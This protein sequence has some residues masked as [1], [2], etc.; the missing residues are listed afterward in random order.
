MTFTGPGRTK[1]SFRDE[2]DIN[3]IMARFQKTGLIDFVEKNAPQYA[4]V[5]GL[6]FQACMDKI[7]SARE[8]F[9]QLPAKWRRRFDDDPAKFLDFVNDPANEAEAIALGIV[10]AKATPPA[11]G[12]GK[13]V[14]G[15]PKAPAEGPEDPP[16][17]KPPK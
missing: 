6:E 1:Q 16:K 7:T 17:S 10:P 4:D 3:L 11:A 12:D 8:M 13:A 9:S 15:A 2:T 5:T 14:S